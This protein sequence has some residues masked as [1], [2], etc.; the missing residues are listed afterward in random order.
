MYFAPEY[1]WISPQKTFF[2]EIYSNIGI[3]FLSFLYRSKIHR[4]TKTKE[5]CVYK[6]GRLR[7]RDYRLLTTCFHQFFHEIN[8]LLRIICFD[9]QN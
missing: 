6:N 9:F 2:V 1:I 3:L 5:N 8:E 7:I 4:K